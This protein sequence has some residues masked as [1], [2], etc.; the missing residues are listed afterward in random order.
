MTSSA[1]T[2]LSH[3]NLVAHLSR[4]EDRQQRGYALAARLNELGPDEAVSIIRLIRRKA[5][6]GHQDSVRLYNG[7]IFRNALFEVIG[8]SK[9]SELVKVAEKRGEFEVLAVLVDLP[10]ET[11][12]E[13]PHQPYL[14][15]SLR[16]IPLGMRKTLAKSPDF[17]LIQRVARDQDYRVIEHLLNNPRLTERDVVRIGSTRPTSPKVLEVIYNHPRWISR[18]SVKK[19]IVCNPYAPISLALRLLTFLTLQDLEL[20]CTMTELSPL[21]VAEA[22]K[23]LQKKGG[24]R[25]VEYRLE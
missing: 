3:F 11:D 24:N 19:T 2:E 10:D 1:Q 16:E 13:R 23:V 25:T 7:L 9:M 4:I 15:I 22:E 14:D 12:G 6:D 20:V 8:R 17:K 18:Y 5:L 21:L